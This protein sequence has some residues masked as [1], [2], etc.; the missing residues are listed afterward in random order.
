MV[1][2]QS[3]SRSEERARRD[4]DKKKQVASRRNGH[5]GDGASYTC[6]GMAGRGSDKELEY[7]KTQRWKC[8]ARVRSHEMMVAFKDIER[9]GHSRG[10]PG[11][12]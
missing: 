10:R 1:C 8:R 4:Q 12:I 3:P 11:S 9:H 5:S 7:S 6:T 2:S